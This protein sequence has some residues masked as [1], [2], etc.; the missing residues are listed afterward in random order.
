LCYGSQKKSLEILVNVSPGLYNTPMTETWTKNTYACDPEECD[1][2]IEITSSDKYGFPSGTIYNVKCPC[3]RT[4]NLVS[5]EDATITPTTERK[6]MET[7]TAPYSYDANTLVTYKSINNGEVTYPTLKVNELE[8]H[9]DSYRRLQDQLA[10]SNGQISQ[11]LDNMT[12]QG[13]YNPNTDKEDI[14]RDLCEILGHEPKQ[15]IT[16]TGNLSFE[17]SYEIPLDEVE[18]FDARYFLQDNLTL[19]SYHGDV[20]IETYEVED[21]DV[22]W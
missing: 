19:D 22:N 15:S 9:L 16:I 5:V 14:L 6:E 11:I 4:P 8:I 18:D 10:I 17:I 20:C 12:T 21:A 7:N 2:L 1:T 13:W 3:G